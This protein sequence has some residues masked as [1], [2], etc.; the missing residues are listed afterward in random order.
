MTLRRREL[1]F[2]YM[3]FVAPGTDQPVMVPVR[4]RD[5]NV[6]GQQPAMVQVIPLSKT[7]D[8]VQLGLI[9]QGQLQVTH[10]AAHGKLFASH[11]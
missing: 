9:V 1:V 10:R 6:I 5:G 7:G 3:P 4:D 8:H 2:K 11:D